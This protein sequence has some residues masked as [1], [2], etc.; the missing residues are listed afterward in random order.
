[1]LLFT[2][3]A[4]RLSEISFDNFKCSEISD[5]HILHY[6][7]YLWNNS[8]EMSVTLQYNNNAAPIITL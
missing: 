4:A 3:S 1:M 6:S 5:I 2:Y 7:H 8:L